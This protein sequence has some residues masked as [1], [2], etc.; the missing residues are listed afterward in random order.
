[1]TRRWAGA[2]SPRRAA[3]RAADQREAAL[4]GRVGRVQ[5][6][7]GERAELGQAQE[8]KGRGERGSA[9]P[10]PSR[11]L[12]PAATRGTALAA[13]HTHRASTRGGTRRPLRTRGAP[14]SCG[15]T[16]L[17]GRCGPPLPAPVPV[18]HPHARV[19]HSSPHVVGA[20]SLAPAAHHAAG[21]SVISSPRRSARR[22]T[23]PTMAP[24]R[25]GRTAAL[26]SSRA[27]C[28]MSRARSSSGSSAWPTRAIRGPSQRRARVSD[29]ARHSE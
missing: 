23:S 26:G 12:R 16:I 15:F 29:Q 10:R 24:P 11:T 1:M 21:A 22:A 17:S 5:A 2:G 28:E 6:A 27:A 8:C 19:A 13:S 9:D 20:G 4:E 18:S 7:W 14:L 3:G 25:T